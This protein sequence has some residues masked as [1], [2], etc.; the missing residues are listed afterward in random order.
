MLAYALR[1]IAL[2]I[3]VLLGVALIVL[4]LF[5]KVGNDPVRVKLGMHATPAAI[6]ELEAKWGLDQPFIVQYA[7]FLKQ[8]VTLDFG[9]SFTTGEKLNAMFK[10]GALVSLFLTAP[11]FVVG[12]LLNVTFAMLIAFY[13]GSWLD[14]YSTF[15]FV[16]AMSISYVVYIMFFQ[17]FFAYALDW[18]PINGYEPGLNSVLYLSLP[19]IITLVINAGPEIRLFRTV[20]LDETKADY[21]R[22]ALAK[23][24][25]PKRVMFKHILKNAMIPVLTY[26]VIGIPS[27]ILG[28]FLLERFFSIPGTGDILISAV[29]NGDFPIIKGLTVLIAI[30]FTLFNLLTDILY[31][32]VDPRIKLD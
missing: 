3:P 14:R 31:A 30:G 25:S 5:T 32:Y 17:Y 2:M 21:V 24:C 9:E 1:R 19:W 10:E 22:T 6:A 18:F 13:R 16:G 26:T 20:F 4:L 7:V 12:L 23:G 15:L 11:P 28:A 29:N 8:I 27:L